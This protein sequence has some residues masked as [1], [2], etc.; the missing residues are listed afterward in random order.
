[1]ELGQQSASVIIYMVCMC[2]KSMLPDEIVFSQQAE[3]QFENRKS[4]EPVSLPVSNAIWSVEKFVNAFL[5]QL[6]VV[7]IVIQ[8]N[9]QNK[10]AAFERQS[11]IF[12]FKK[13]SRSTSDKIAQ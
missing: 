3:P 8:G 5:L 4:G 10:K 2:F 9:L 7:T 13:T 12:C 1:M 6:S 11:T